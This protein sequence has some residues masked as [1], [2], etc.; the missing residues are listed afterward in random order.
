MSLNADNLAGLS[1]I[2]VL[3]KVQLGNFPLLNVEEDLISDD[4]VP[5][6]GQWQSIDFLYKTATLSI[7][8][9]MVGDDEFYDVVIEWS[10]PLVSKTRSRQTQ[11]SRQRLIADVTDNNGNRYMIGN[12]EDLLRF[13]IAD[14]TGAVAG[15]FNGGRCAIKGRLRQRPPFYAP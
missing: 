10:E 14:S 7:K 8:P 1:A 3:G 15:E 6:S 13:E 11:T 12:K 4:V 2:L 5:V 9:V